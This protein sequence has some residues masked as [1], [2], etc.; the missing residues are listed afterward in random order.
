MTESC[1][2]QV[3]GIE[4]ESDHQVSLQTGHIRKKKA[5]G[6]SFIQRLGKDLNG[7]PLTGAGLD[8]ALQKA[9]SLPH[10]QSVSLSGTAG[11]R[12]PSQEQGCRQIAITTAIDSPFGGAVY[13][14]RCSDEAEAL[15]W[16]QQASRCREEVNSRYHWWLSKNRIQRRL[17]RVYTHPYCQTI[18]AFLIMANFVTSMVELELRGVHREIF[19]SL[20]LV[21][22]LIFLVELILN[23]GCNWFWGFW[24]SAFNIFDLIVVVVTTVSLLPYVDFKVQL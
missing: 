8:K 13:L 10:D 7:K 14:L 20:D 16:V 9:A 11:Q 6:V 18:V 17:Q 22:T 12:A 5:F 24:G 2:S 1:Q 3:T 23:M 15:E 4:L 21:F 19:Q